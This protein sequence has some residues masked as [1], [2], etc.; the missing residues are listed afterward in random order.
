MAIYDDR[1]EIE[2]PGLLTG[3]LTIGDVRDGVSKLRN[4]VIGRVFKELDLIEQWG[5]GFQRMVASCR[6]LGLPE[7][8]LEEVAFRF[9]VTFGLQRVSAE[10][11][12][13]DLRIMELIQSREADGGASPQYLSQTVGISSRAVRDRLARLTRAGRIVAVGK[14]IYDPNKRYLLAKG[15]EP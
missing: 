15:D 7:P 9:R 4:R 3:G 12:D 5:S 14:S 1:L 11:D 10:A 2:N 8:E 13:M 6:E